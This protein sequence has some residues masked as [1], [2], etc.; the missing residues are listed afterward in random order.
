MSCCM[1]L[2]HSAVL[3][4]MTSATAPVAN[5]GRAWQYA[6]IYVYMC[7]HQYCTI[8]CLHAYVRSIPAMYTFVAAALASVC[9]S[10]SG[11]C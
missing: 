10:V 6:C 9:Q 7:V 2:R 4:L 3:T 8:H 1:Q 11:D 5:L